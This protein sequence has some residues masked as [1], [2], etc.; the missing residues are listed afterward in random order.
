ML[1]EQVTE[2]TRLYESGLSLSQV[3]D[4]L[5]VNQ[6]TMRIAIMKAGVEIRS[7]TGAA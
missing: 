5:K 3:A 1:P 4:A 7:A 2:A 6:E